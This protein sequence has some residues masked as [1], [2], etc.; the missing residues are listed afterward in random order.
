MAK[1]KK[2]AVEK[3]KNVKESKHKTKITKRVKEAMKGNEK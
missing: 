1:T 2:V 3:V